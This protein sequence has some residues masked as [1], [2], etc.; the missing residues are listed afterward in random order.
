MFES[1]KKHNIESLFE[2]LYWICDNTRE[3]ISEKLVLNTNKLLRLESK[4]VEKEV[5]EHIEEKSPKS[6]VYKS[7]FD[8]FIEFYR[9][10]LIC[11]KLPL[12]KYNRNISEEQLELLYARPQDTLGLSEQINVYLNHYGL[13]TNVALVSATIYQQTT[14]FPAIFHPNIFKDINK[15]L[16]SQGLNGYKILNYVNGLKKYYYLA[17]AKVNKKQAAEDEHDSNKLQKENQ[18]Q[19]SLPLFQNQM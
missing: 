5:I 18:E 19:T 17:S 14:L 11:R 6:R 10:K 1:L 3:V 7:K 15:A 16:V 2:L 4:L 12:T 13:N 8:K 9:D